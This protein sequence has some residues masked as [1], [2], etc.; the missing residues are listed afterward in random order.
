LWWSHSPGYSWAR[1]AGV[2]S[3]GKALLAVDRDGWL[4]VRAL[5]DTD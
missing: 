4:P 1:C 5:A 3:G 2:G